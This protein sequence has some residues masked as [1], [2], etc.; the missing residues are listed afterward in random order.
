M[1]RG[2]MPVQYLLFS[3]RDDVFPGTRLPKAFKV[4]T[5]T[6]LGVFRQASRRDM[7]QVHGTLPTAGTY[8]PGR[9]VSEYKS[10]G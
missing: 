1:G 6:Y 2:V 5:C 8:P 4:H 10:G 9:Y 7:V 3:L